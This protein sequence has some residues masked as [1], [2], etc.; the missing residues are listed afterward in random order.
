MNKSKKTSIAFG[1]LLVCVGWLTPPAAAARRLALGTMS[2]NLPVLPKRAI[3]ANKPRRYPGD[4]VDHPLQPLSA[5]EI[6]ET[7]R[8]IDEYFAKHGLPTDRLM[9]PYV[10]LQEPPKTAVPGLPGSWRRNAFPAI[11]GR[12]SCITQRIVYG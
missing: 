10:T 1:V 2:P 7:V 9:F 12:R 5:R 4:A 11:A 6:R 3:A 8:I